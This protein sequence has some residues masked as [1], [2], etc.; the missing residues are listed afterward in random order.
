MT[1]GVRNVN[2]FV[3]ALRQDLPNAQD[4]ARARARLVAAGVVV[5]AAILAPEVSA[6]AAA[7]VGQVGLLA[8]LS[9]WPLAAK[10]SLGAGIAV[11]AALPTAWYVQDAHVQIE[12]PARRAAPGQPSRLAASS[13]MTESV[14]GMRTEKQEPE[15]HDAREPTALPLQARRTSG[16][17]SGI[18][19]QP[20]AG[21]PRSAGRDAL[22][23]ALRPDS[24]AGASARPAVA[25][26]PL[27]ATNASAKRALAEETRLIERALAAL[28]AEDRIEAAHWLAEHSRRFPTG[29]LS[30]EREQ[31]LERLRRGGP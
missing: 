25:A 28:H 17:P 14:M 13:G 26:F 27:I 2:L 23:S 11:A 24:S 8:K 19:Q 18:L 12:P 10:V 4:E 31:A 21:Q 9:A 22:D 15:M 3:D 29:E 6:A 1:P 7:G 20:P 16:I 30:R 5:T